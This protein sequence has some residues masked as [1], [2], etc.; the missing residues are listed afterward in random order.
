M[1]R[2]IRMTLRIALSSTARPAG[3]SMPG[4]R[5]A[6][7]AL[8]EVVIIGVFLSVTVQMPMRFLR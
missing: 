1:F 2:A 4:T 5:V 8:S 7:G 6:G 3:R